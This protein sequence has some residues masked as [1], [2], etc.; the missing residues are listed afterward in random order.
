MKTMALLVRG[1]KRGGTQ[2]GTYA[3]AYRRQPTSGRRGRRLRRV[4][5]ISSAIT[6]VITATIVLPPM[7]AF[8][9]SAWRATTLP[10]PGQNAILSSVSCPASGICV[11]VGSY[12]DSSTGVSYGLIESLSGGTWTASAPPLSGLNPFATTNPGNNGLV[13]ELDLVSCPA[14]DWCVATGEYQDS[15]GNLQGMVETFSNGAWTATTAPSSGL[16]P[17][18]SVPGIDFGGGGLSCPASGSCVAVAQYNTSGGTR[19]VIETLATGTWTSQTA[20]FSNLSPVAGA[21]PM[22]LV[23]VSCPVTGNCVA[24]G[25]YVDSSGFTHG[26]IET[27][28]GTW[29]DS[30]APTADLSP[31]PFHGI[32]NT[33]TDFGILGLSHVSCSSSGDCI[34]LGTYFAQLNSD[35]QALLEAGN[36]ATNIWSDSTLSLAGLNP[37]P[38]TSNASL[39]FTGVSCVS[40]SSFCALGS[41]ND[42]S[43]GSWGLTV[44]N[45][46]ATT[47]SFNGLNPAPS[48]PPIVSLQSGLSCPTSDYCAGGG[49]YESGSGFQGLIEILSGSTW[50]ATAV[51]SS[52]LN[53]APS[54]NS[55]TNVTAVSCDAPRDCVVVGTYDDASTQ[56]HLVAIQSVDTTSTVVSCNPGSVTLE[57]SSTCTATVTDTDSGTTSAPTGTMT[58]TA[59]SSGGTFSQTAACS[60]SLIGVTQSSCSVTYTPGLAESAGPTTITASYSGDQ[61]HV[62]GSGTATVTV[63]V[64]QASVSPAALSFGRV[65]TGK[66]SEQNVTVANATTA[67]GALIITGANNVGATEFTI[68]WPNSTC[69]RSGIILAPG[70][71]CTIAELF[72][73]TKS[74]DAK[75]GVS[76]TLTIAD[77][78]PNGTQTVSMTGK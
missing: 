74:T 69:R 47:G 24:V 45:G 36:I 29:T 28:N 65:H 38:T 3:G 68:D 35:Q 76:G 16:S 9:G 50:S 14:S 18:P 26:L 7:T 15:S 46:I 12:H 52:G 40:S 37:A 75:T 6:L 10:D 48:S 31:L 2:E 1:T 23:D 32:D 34:I 30:T 57:Q 62:A 25:D 39:S 33:G 5:S 22:H 20:P 58:F 63:G 11:A 55:R 60:L 72:S 54:A 49:S 66:S 27:L 71:S 17:A 70:Q 73:P 4:L 61:T 21:G 43:G 77:N 41:Y 19:P 59:A 13:S 8:G 67:T 53:P 42:S 78:D 51:P 56:L 44:T 64:P